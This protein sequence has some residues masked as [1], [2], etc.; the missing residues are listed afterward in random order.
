MVHQSPHR[1]GNTV[2]VVNKNATIQNCSV[3]D[4]TDCTKTCRASE[5]REKAVRW[6][7][8]PTTETQDTQVTVHSIVRA[9]TAIIG[10]PSRVTG[11]NRMKLNEDEQPNEAIN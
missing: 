8:I 4:V 7:S 11:N 6:R 9:G 5:G 2:K 1:K 10:I 3:W